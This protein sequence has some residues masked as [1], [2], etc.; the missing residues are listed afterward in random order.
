MID[1]LNVNKKGQDKLRKAGYRPDGITSERPGGVESNR[2]STAPETPEPRRRRSATLV[3]RPVQQM[4][5]ASM[6]ALIDEGLAQLI[7]ARLVATGLRGES[8]AVDES[9][10][11]SVNNVTER[12]RKL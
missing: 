3:F 2:C 1:E 9:S 11:F 12:S 4:S 8:Q 7:A 10:S 6:R 5:E